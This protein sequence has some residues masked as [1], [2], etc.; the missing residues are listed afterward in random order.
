MRVDSFLILADFGGSGGGSTEGR[1]VS[2]ELSVVGSTTS[3]L[4][5]WFNSFSAASDCLTASNSSS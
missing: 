4:W 2:N 3:G 1:S 5:F